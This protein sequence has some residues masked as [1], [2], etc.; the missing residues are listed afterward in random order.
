M[1]AYDQSE[2]RRLNMDI[3]KH[4]VNLTTHSFYHFSPA[5]YFSP[6]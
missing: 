2:Q 3:L 5:Y 6:F 4:T 1:M